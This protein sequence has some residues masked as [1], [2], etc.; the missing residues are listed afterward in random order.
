MGF[1]ETTPPDADIYA[2]PGYQIAKTA[3][4]SSPGK[5]DLNGGDKMW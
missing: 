2:T 3:F 1:L 5:W 4:T